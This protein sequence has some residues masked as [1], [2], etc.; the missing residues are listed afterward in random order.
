MT[1]FEEMSELQQARYRA[2]AYEQAALDAYYAL[3]HL[4]GRDLIQEPLKDILLKT[5]NMLFARLCSLGR[6]NPENEFNK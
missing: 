6:L 4:P 5:E 2:A 3:S 1:T